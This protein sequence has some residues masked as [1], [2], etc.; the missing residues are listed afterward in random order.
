MT[1]WGWNAVT[2]LTHGL[3]LFSCVKGG[4]SGETRCDHRSRLGRVFLRHGRV[5]MGHGQAEMRHEDL[6]MVGGLRRVASAC[7]VEPPA[8]TNRRSRA[9]LQRCSQTA[10]NV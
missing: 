6:L 5:R 8:P 1:P 10:T 4:M 2:G 7:D 9:S 3:A